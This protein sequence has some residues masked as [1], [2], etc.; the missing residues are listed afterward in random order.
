MIFFEIHEKFW[1]FFSVLAP[2]AETK[3]APQN[4]PVFIEIPRSQIVNENDTVV[5]EA[6]VGSDSPVEFS[7]FLNGVEISASV[8]ALIE[9]G[10]RW[11]RITI[12]RSALKSAEYAVVA[13]NRTGHEIA[14]CHLEVKGFQNFC[15][16]F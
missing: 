11:T 5:L 13:E 3:P 10:D 4:P 14:K 2:I 7:W 8:D 9:R 12:R 16:I 15:E 6:V 1:K